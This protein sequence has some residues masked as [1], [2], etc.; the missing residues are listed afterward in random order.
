MTKPHKLF[1]L[2]GVGAIV[3][4]VSLGLLLPY[5]NEYIGMPKLSLYALAVPAVFFALY[6]LICY[7]IRIDKWRPFL[8]GIAVANLL[9]C[10]V[11]IFLV[12]SHYKELTGWGLAYF[13]GEVAVILVIA[14]WELRTARRK[15]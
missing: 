7:F 3:S 14:Y 12:F 5:L 6:S 1:L 9:Y 10:C 13:V 8:Q 2:D 11:T 15:L 4:A